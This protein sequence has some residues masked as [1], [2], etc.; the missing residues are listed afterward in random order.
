[1][2]YYY[3]HLPGLLLA[4]QKAVPVDKLLQVSMLQAVTPVKN[5]LD[6]LEHKINNK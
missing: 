6:N 2:K 4:N 3:L 5:K 1:M